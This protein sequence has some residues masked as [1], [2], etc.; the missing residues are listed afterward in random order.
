M[1]GNLIKY[2]PTD[3]EIITVHILDYWTRLLNAVISGSDDPKFHIGT[4]ITRFPIRDLN[5]PTGLFW[6]CV[7]I[8]CYNRRNSKQWNDA[9]V[10]RWLYIQIWSR[11]EKKAI[12]YFRKF[13]F[14]LDWQ[15]GT[16]TWLAEQTGWGKIN[17]AL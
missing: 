2:H 5:S 9:D 16:A 15:S 17:T 10:T 12:I 6:S 3:Y 1:S 14:Y 7:P 13:L 11:L 8:H 4:F